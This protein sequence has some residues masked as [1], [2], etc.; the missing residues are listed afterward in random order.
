MNSIKMIGKCIDQPMVVA[1]FSKIVTPAL[2]GG[3]TLM[4][5]KDLQKEPD[6]EQRRKK[7][8]QNGLTWAGTISSAIIATRG[9]KIKPIN[10]KTASKVLIPTIIGGA[11]FLTYKDVKKESS[12]QQKKKKIAK[13]LLLSA[14]TIALTLI[15]LKGLKPLKI[16]DKIIFKGFEGL[17][18]AKEFSGFSGLSPKFN[19]KKIQNEQTQLINNFLSNNKVSEKSGSILNKM[20]TKIATPENIKTLTEEFQNNSNGLKL[21]DDLIPEPKNISAKEIFGEIGRLSLMGFLPVAGGI[22]GG[23]LG[24]KITDEKWK[25]KV[26]NKI[27]EGTYQYLANIFLCNVGAGAA[28]GIMEKLNIRSKAQRAAGMVAGILITGVFGGS[29]IANF[30]SKKLIDPLIGKKTENNNTL[31]DERKPEALDIGLHT[32]DIATVAVMSG[33]KWIEPA[34]P[35]LYSISGYRAG[36][37]YRNGNE[38]KQSIE[39]GKA[40]KNYLPP[41]SLISPAFEAF[42]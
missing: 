3:A 35:I 41:N 27:K 22:G 7:L 39:E 5:Y 30:L 25:E 13:D 15:S 16:K 23:I 28:L 9:L 42:S 37:G 18:N 19:L 32:D 31:Y 10:I 6:K 21:I 8:I 38:A 36:I 34:L 12:E 29:A 40:D 2:I 33:L 24:D 26:P 20:K 14:G 4:T 17:K 1:K 11:G